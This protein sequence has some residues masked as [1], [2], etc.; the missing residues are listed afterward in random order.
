MILWIIKDGQKTGP[1]ED[2]E[3][4]EMIREG[5]VKRD[6]RVWHEAAEEW[7]LASDVGVLA[8]ELREPAKEPGPIEVS[9]APFRGWPRLGARVIDFMIYGTILDLLSVALGVNLMGDADSSGWYVIGIILPVI[10]M[11]AAMV[12]SI[13]YTPGKWILGMRVETVLGQKLSIL[14]AFVRSTRVWV[15]GVG[16]FVP[17]MMIIGCSMSLWFGKKKG[18]MLWDLQGGFHVV[19]GQITK[20]RIVLFWAILFLIMT[21]NISPYFPEILA[22]DEQGLQEKLLRKR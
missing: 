16:M 13:G 3:V 10:I 14:Q 20:K 2:Y 19:G 4:R 17:P 18:R 1:F 8:S 22:G 15:L 7:L 5:K 21:I 6:T 11:E 9:L 12:G